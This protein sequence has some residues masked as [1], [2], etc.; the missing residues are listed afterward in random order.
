MHLPGDL[1]MR[2]LFE[3]VEAGDDARVFAPEL[4]RVAAGRGVVGRGRG[5][6]ELVAQFLLPLVHQRR[7]GQHEEP[8]HHAARQQFLEHEAGLDGLAQTHFVGQQ[9]AAAQRPQHAQGGAQLVIE[10]LHAAIRQAEQVVGLVGNPPQR[11]PFAQRITAQVGQGEASSPE[12]RAAAIR[13]ASAPAAAP[14]ARR[15]VSTGGTEI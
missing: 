10:P 13:C 2:R 1:Q 4:L 14:G 6:A 12:T 9:G 7:H 8:L 3:R 15:Q 11:R 5:E